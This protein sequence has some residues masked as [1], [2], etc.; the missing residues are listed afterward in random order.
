MCLR[1][2]GGKEY[3]VY[4][5][6]IELSNGMLMPSIG[7][8]TIN[9][10]SEQIENNV[11]FAIQNGYR[12]IDTANRYTNEKSVGRGIKKSEISRNEIF[13]ETKLAPTFYETKDAIDKTLERLGVDY[14]DLMLLH[15]PLNNYIV[16]YQ[17][18]EKAYQEGKIKALGLSNF[19][20]E[21][22]QEILDHCTIK[23]VVMQVECHPYYPA[24]KVRDFCNQNGITLQSWFPLG[25]GD[26]GLLNEELF[27]KLAAKYHKTTSQI[28]LKWHTQMGFSAVPGSRN[29]NHILENIDLFDFDLTAQEMSEIE[30]LNK[31]QP[32]YQVTQESQHKLSTTIPDVDGEK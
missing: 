24:D 32:F 11:A 23:P 4:M 25:H 28:I 8:G 15:H 27:K 31:H 26:S 19:S 14:V 12:L 29:E 21:Q 20:I 3:K 5:K 2:T 7:L 9:Q 10:F 16:G 1:A 30:K 22:I 17:M 13:I 18:M 6:T